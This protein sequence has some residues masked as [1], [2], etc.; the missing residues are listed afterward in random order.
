MN[1]RS[2]IVRKPNLV[3][4]STLLVAKVKKNGK[5]EETSSSENSFRALLDEEKDKIKDT[6]SGENLLEAPEEGETDFPFKSFLPEKSSILKE[7]TMPVNLGMIDNPQIT[8][9]ATTLS[10]EEQKVMTEYL[11]KGKK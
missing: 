1:M 4:K 6:S 8:Y 5:I 2:N 11:Q 7:D 10:P 3:A 9:T